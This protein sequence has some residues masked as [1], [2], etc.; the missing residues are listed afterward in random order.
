MAIS[1]TVPP[2]TG[3]T[4][5]QLTEIIREGELYLGTQATMAVAADVRALAFAGFLAAAIV[6]LIGGAVA[7]G[8][9]SPALTVIASFCVAGLLSSFLFAVFAA[10]PIS[11]EYAGNSPSGWYED[12]INGITFENSLIMQAINYAAMIDTNA[13]AMLKNSQRMTIAIWI[14][15]VTLVFGAIVFVCVV[16]VPQAIIVWATW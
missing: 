2:L 7:L 3:A 11:F 9:T 4:R 10:R 14:S 5:E 1:N 8:E 13:A 6:A 12:I 15:S 16:A